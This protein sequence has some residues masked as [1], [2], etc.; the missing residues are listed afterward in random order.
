M[1]SD[2]HSITL[3]GQYVGCLAVKHRYILNE[4]LYQAIHHAHSLF[5]HLHHTSEYV[6]RPG[7]SA[8]PCQSVQRDIDT[9]ST[10]T[11]AV[12]LEIL[13]LRACQGRSYP[14]Q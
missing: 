8:L 6:H 10:N 9:R 7:L 3:N 4:L 14:Q 2:A 11:S 13:E 5:S 1:C 12:N